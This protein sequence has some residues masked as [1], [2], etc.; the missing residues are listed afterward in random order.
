L[1]ARRTTCGVIVTNGR[2]ILLGHATRS[3]RWDIP[4]GVTEPGESSADTAARELHEETGLAVPPAAL[5]DLGVHRYLAAKDIALFAWIPPTMPSPA[6]LHC[7]S[8]FTTPGGVVLPEFDRFGTFAWDD[9]LARIGRNLARVLG[10]VRP[11]L[12]P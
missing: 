5:V 10:S 11:A 4:K 3:P 1:A 6:A 2:D 7:R 8:T 9:A 12:R